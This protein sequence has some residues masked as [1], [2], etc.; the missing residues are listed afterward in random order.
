MAPPTIRCMIFGHKFI[1]ERTGEFT[2]AI[3]CKRCR[4]V[5][6]VKDFSPCSKCGKP[7]T[8]PE[9]I[10]GMCKNCMNK[11]DAVEKKDVTQ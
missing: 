3:L 6:D 2:D 11:L 4:F 7:T 9:D 5:K 8:G 10:Y 1:K